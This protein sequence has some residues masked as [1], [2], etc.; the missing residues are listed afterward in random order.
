MTRRKRSKPAE[1]TPGGWPGNHVSTSGD[2]VSSPAISAGRFSGGAIIPALALL[3]LVA[4]AAYHN[5]FTGPFTFDD[6]IWINE[7][8]NIRHLWPIGAVLFPPDATVVGGRPVVSLTLAL[9]Y[10]LG[11][12]NVWGYHAFNL[13]IHILAAWTLFGVLRR[14]LILPRLRERFGSAATPLALAAAIL[15]MIHPLQTESVTYVIQRTEALMGLFYLL[16]LYGVI[17]G[18]TWG[19]SR[20]WYVVAVLSCLLGMAT[21]EVTVTAPVIVLV[22]DRMFL[23]GTFREA[24][25]QR[26]GL[27]L[28]LAATWS[29]V[30]LLLISTGFYGGTAGFGVQKFT[31]WTYLLTQPGVLVHYLGLTFWPR[32][33]CLDY[34]WPAAHGWND[35]LGPAVLMVGLLALTFW[36]LVRGWGWG[37]LGVWF[38]LVLAPTSSFVPI[39]D[40]A[41]EHR[42]YLPLAAVVTG[43]VLGGY[44][45]GQGVVGGGKISGPVVQ[46]MGVSLLILAGAALG[47]LTLRRNEDYRSE[48]SIWEDTV[49][50]APGNER[51][52][53]NLG[54]TLNGCRRTD[55]AIAHYQKALELKPDFADAHYN[56][57]LALVNRGQR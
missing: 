47:I 31:W 21:K 41:F 6:A 27:Y 9:N 44:L 16:V 26:Y 30:P 42:M 38:F 25:R 54:N 57:G 48:L 43:V 39:Q 29:V 34:G 56:L 46:I 55:E 7:N 49:A 1:N 20:W 2:V 50:K 17:R 10:A 8:S 28:A 37:F 3:L 18:A 19:G 14:T 53:N 23:A 15:W 4:V 52:E 40:A 33:L 35:V 36:A 51:A 11:G 5:S 22:Y 32:G 12:T 24:W 45:V 13:V